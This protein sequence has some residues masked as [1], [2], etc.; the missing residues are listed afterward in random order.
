MPAVSVL[1]G[2][3]NAEVYLRAALQSL[4]EQTLEDFE[5]ILIDDASADASAQIAEETARKDTRFRLFRNDRNK[6]LTDTLNRAFQLSVGP[7]I[8]R[9]DADDIAVPD[10]LQKQTAFLTSHPETDILGTWAQDI[11]ELGRREQIRTLPGSHER[12]VTVLAWY[13]PLVHPTVM[14]RRRVLEQLSGY[15]KA[16]RTSQDYDLWFRAAAA[17]FSFA[18]LPEPLLLYRTGSDYL[19]RKS[20]AYRM[21]EFRIRIRG[22][23]RFRAHWYDRVSAVLSLVLAVLPHAL[24]KAAKRMD[25]RH[26]TPR[27][28]TYE[29]ARGSGS[30][31]STNL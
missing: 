14:L 3:Y 12:I 31:V 5:V 17:G 23:R 29:R 2:F 10:R 7:L 19:T 28:R 15:S 22:T 13:N 11:D 24:F 27:A 21:N 9:M 18:N 6:G 30:G 4:A 16:F 26:R 25:P 20:Y 1:F 8:A